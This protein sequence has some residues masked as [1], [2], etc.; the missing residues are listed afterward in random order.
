MVL[1]Q[2]LKVGN[3]VFRYRRQIYRTLVAQDRAIDKAFKVG[4]YGSQTRRGARHGALGGSIIGN[5]ITQDDDGVGDDA[6]PQ[7][8]KS[9]KTYSQYKTYNRRSTRRTDRYKRQYYCLPRKR[10]SSTR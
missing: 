8:P 2:I 10:R 3:I 6:I 9:T 4:G 1:G 7:I 5:L